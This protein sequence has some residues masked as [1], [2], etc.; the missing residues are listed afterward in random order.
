MARR[1]PRALKVVMSHEKVCD[2]L[3]CLCKK[4]SKN[5]VEWEKQ[6]KDT[7]LGVGF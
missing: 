5:I 2:G 6:L 3:F 4:R 1:R 7:Q